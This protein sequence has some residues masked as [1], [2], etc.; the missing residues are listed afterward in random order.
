M[1]HYPDGGGVWWTCSLCKF[2]GQTISM[3]QKARKIQDPS[4]AYM[5]LLREI[6]YTGEAPPMLSQETLSNLKSF[7]DQLASREKVWERCWNYLYTNLPAEASAILHRHKIGAFST[8]RNLKGLV[9]ACDRVL[10]PELRCRI[11]RGLEKGVANTLMMRYESLPG[12][13][14]SILFMSNSPKVLLLDNSEPGLMGLRDSLRYNEHVIALSNPILYLIARKRWMNDVDSPPP[15]ICYADS[16]NWFTR[17][18]TDSWKTLHHNRVI[19][20]DRDPANCLRMARVLGER[21]YIAPEPVYQSNVAPV[22]IMAD[23]PILELYN[24]WQNKAVPWLKYLANELSFST[25]SDAMGI[26]N[27]LGTPL[28]SYEKDRL[29]SHCNSEQWRRIRCLFDGE[30]ANQSFVYRDEVFIERPARGWFKLNQKQ[31][32]PSTETLVSEVMIKLQQATV[33]RKEVVLNGSL[34]F[35]GNQIPFS[36]R[37]KVIRKDP[38]EWVTSFCL[39][40]ELKYPE[41][42]RDYRKIL[43][44]LAIQCSHPKVVKEVEK[45]GWV[46]NLAAYVFPRFFID[47]E[48]SITH[49]EVTNT[50]VSGIPGQRLSGTNVQPRPSLIQNW[51]TPGPHTEIAWCLITCLLANL[52]A[53]PMKKAR[54][55][56]SLVL[57]GD[58]AVETL[59]HLGQAIGLIQFSLSKEP[60]DWEIEQILQMEQ[61]HD[62][63]CILRIDR[64]IDERWSTQL[65]RV[66]HRNVILGSTL[67]GLINLSMHAPWI[68]IRA[69]DKDSNTCTWLNDIELVIPY[70]LAVMTKRKMV[71]RSKAE[72]PLSLFDD[73]MDLILPIDT[74]PDQKLMIASARSRLISWSCGTLYSRIQ[75]LLNY[76]KLV[77]EGVVF[78]TTNKSP[79]W[80]DAKANLLY[81]QRDKLFDCLKAREWYLPADHL[82]DATFTHANHFAAKLTPTGWA[83]NLKHFNQQYVRWLRQVQSGSSNAS[84]NL[85]SQ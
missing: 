49:P 14:S 18:S 83:I 25:P 4:T 29:K 36:E 52:L 53:V 56:T 50:T 85:S 28:S 81:V 24:T 19:F 41:I 22:R 6:D 15:F 32:G 68:A 74:T 67:K 34:V 55:G 80:E 69:P 76:E 54:L 31:D 61:A 65:R 30:N 82:F 35:R 51:L 5:E 70:F 48:G 62:L 78:G 38:A 60:T 46:S 44:D 43:L 75:A 12:R 45:V 10:L 7:E 73:L 8:L 47:V 42:N 2:S 33:V 72:W 11:P 77:D 1:F 23:K 21:G 64:V 3:Y 13:M 20:W 27:S 17:Y 79:I 40:R 66:S 26:L 59:N 71:Q 84:D 9:G 58:T 63:P 57:P 39:S 37:E 16:S